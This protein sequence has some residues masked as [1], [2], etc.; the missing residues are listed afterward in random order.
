M[1]KKN[2]IIISYYISRYSAHEFR[3]VCTDLKVLDSEVPNLTYLQSGQPPVCCLDRCLRSLS[4]LWAPHCLRDPHLRSDE[5]DPNPAKS[6]PS[7]WPDTE[8]KRLEVTS[9]RSWV[10]QCSAAFFCLCTLSFGNLSCVCSAVFGQYRI[11]WDWL[12]WTEQKQARDRLAIQRQVNPC[13]SKHVCALSHSCA[14]NQIK[15]ADRIGIVSRYTEIAFSFLHNL[16]L[17][18]WAW[19]C[20]QGWPKPT[21]Y[22]F[23]SVDKDE[24]SN[25]VVSALGPWFLTFLRLSWPGAQHLAVRCTR[26]TVRLQKKCEDKAKN[27]RSTTW[28]TKTLC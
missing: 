3:Y 4:P 12:H 19:N 11:T 14:P 26:S 2:I 10:L 23:E 17:L 15:F 22:W 6:P 20:H 18:V 5:C 27:H 24:V 21:F 25:A 28:S 16:R 13:R 8:I 7:I 1:F 9:G